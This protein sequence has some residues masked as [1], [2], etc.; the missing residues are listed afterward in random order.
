MTNERQSRGRRL[1]LASEAACLL[2]VARVALF[3]L[4]F[5]HLAAWFA[6][7]LLGPQAEGAARRRASFEV[8]KA[9]F[10][11]WRYFPHGSTCFHRAL[12]AQMMLRRR[13]VGTTLWY[14]ASRQPSRGVRGHVWVQDGEFII[15]GRDASLQCTALATFPGGLLQ[16]RSE[17]LCSG[18][19]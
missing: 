1:A 8:H 18:K 6:R 10:L 11:A 17:T 5:R 4:P 2:L 13:Q 15:V 14:G 3:I 19:A 12:A 7:P 9:I 16:A